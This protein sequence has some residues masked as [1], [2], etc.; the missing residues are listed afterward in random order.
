MQVPRR[1]SD[2]LKKP[3]DGPFYI[4]EDG[5]RRLQEKLARRKHALPDLIAEAQRTAA[6]G[7][8]SDNAAYKES[9]AALRRTTWQ[10]LS[11]EDQIKRA[12]VI[13]QGIHASGVVEL[14]S[15]VTI[16]TDKKVTTYEIVGPHETDPSRGRI[17]Y[18]SPLGAALIGHAKDD[19]ITFQSANGAQKY[20][21]TE[22]R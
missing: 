3:D 22:I 21:I 16:E 5:L 1:R 20:H 4:T 18:R 12:I 8:R 13:A 9:K 11:L 15:T 7:D 14:G 19:V 2:A 17:S 10:V 6:E